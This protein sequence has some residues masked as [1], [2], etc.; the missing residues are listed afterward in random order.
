MNLQ[1]RHKDGTLFPIAV[2]LGSV[3]TRT[4]LLVVA[5]VTDTTER[6]ELG[7]S[8]RQRESELA[9]LIDSSP[10]PHARWDS[11]LHFTYANAAFA[12]LGEFPQ[13]NVRVATRLIRDVFRTG[14]PQRAEFAIPGPN[15]AAE[16]EVRYVP[17]LAPD[18]SV[19][20]V[21]AIGRD[22]TQMK[23]MERDL[24][25]REQELATL[26]DNSPDVILR[27]DRNLRNLYINSAWE[28]ATGI[29][30]ETALGKTS[31]EL[32]LPPDVVSL[33]E[34]VIRQVLKTRSPVTVEFTYPSPGGPMDHEVRH[35]P[36][37]TDG[38]VSSILLIG[39]DI[40]EEKRLKTL[41][42]AKERERRESEGRFRSMADSAPVLIWMSGADKLC[43]WCNQQWLTF[44]GR[45]MAQEL[46][47]GW[48]DSIHP[49]DIDR[50]F[51]TY[52]THFDARE[53][54]SMEYRLR[55]H[56]GEWRW[57]LDTGAPRYDPLKKFLGYIGTC[58][59]IT[60]LKVMQEQQIIAE[61]KLRERDQELAVL[62]DS[63]PDSLV[64]FD[65]NMRATH[66]NAAFEKMTGIPLEAVLGETPDQV[67]LPKDIK[68]AAAAVV[69]NVFL[70]RQP[71][72]LLWTFTSP[73]G[74]RDLDLR[75]IPEFAA[76]GSVSAVFSIA[77]DVTEKK[78]AEEALLQ[79]ERELAT[80]F[81]H[82][83]DVISRRDRNFRALYLNA[84]W[85]KM[86]G[87]AR[88][89]G[90]GKSGR[91]LGLPAAFVDPQERLI[92]RVLKSKRPLMAE[93]TFPSPNGVIELEVRHVPEFAADGSVSSVLLIG[94][95]VTEQKRL[96]N[97][98]A[99]NQRDIQALTTSL[100][101]AQEQER[102]RVAR[103][104]HDSLSQH[105][106]ALAAEMGGIAAELPASSRAGQ[107][108]RIAREHALRVAE[109]ARQ[110]AR[111]LH[112]AILEDL[113][114]TKGLQNLCDEFSYQQKIPIK[115]RVTEPFSAPSI[116]AASCVYRIAQEVLNNVAKHSQAKNVS[117]HLTGTR[118]Q[119]RLSIRDNGIG[120]DP[121]AVRGAG[122]LGLV[123]MEE[124]ARM[125]GAKLSI[126]ARPGNGTQVDLIV[127]LQ[128]KAHEKSA[129]SAGR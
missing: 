66:V 10:D 49:E 43:T 30:R 13:G 14:E 114:L 84:A 61:R 87:I 80:L 18:G 116:E 108:L 90:L 106:G 91:E 11:N 4:G 20:A 76:D 53:P 95:D 22:I 88:E 23:Q 24:R 83:P 9:A 39:R 51:Q 89:K 73:H 59:D 64:R 62:F 27:L 29:S 19:A 124:R 77:R 32:G 46:G 117:V 21:L 69:R 65:S 115:F 8:I 47:N 79:R 121:A 107:H 31:R 92:R 55:R 41:A 123:S 113:G 125:A 81:D 12:K 99:A 128:G 71:A 48:T 37:F 34:R 129:N 74:V 85:E 67:P 16:H 119:L 110:I 127:P 105:L 68:Q 2:G 50:S 112:P 93:F 38:A 36:E 122:G 56:D 60:A 17:E 57:I 63:S 52:T 54:F 126:R 120:F 94:R 70:T 96:Q 35:I 58:I 102:R 98:A 5:F 82:S 104:I 15:G 42:V 44:V 7:Q 111:Q 103:D 26:F 45:T 86:T 3:E 78:R 28:R 109:E 75:Y 40:T 101:T 6:K 33:Q 100:M 97:L 25:Q 72:T 1:G 118:S